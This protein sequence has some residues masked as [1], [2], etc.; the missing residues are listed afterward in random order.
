MAAAGASLLLAGGLAAPPALSAPPARP[1]HRPACGQPDQAP[2]FETPARTGVVPDVS[3]MDLQMARDK[4]RAAGFRDLDSEDAGGRGRHQIVDRNW[5]VVDQN[6]PA[7]SRLPAR[8][9]L[10]FRVLAYGDAGAPPVPDRA[11]PGRMPRLSC[12][13]LQEAQDTLRSAGF[14]SGRSQDAT[15]RGRRPILD[16]HWTVVGQAPPPGG[17]YPKRTTVTLRVVKNGEPSPCR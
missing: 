5:V 13:D 16:R 12:F 2:G 3:C 9:R 11:R 4:A 1:G 8:A 6:P 7:G 14:R 17:T 10:V 15:G